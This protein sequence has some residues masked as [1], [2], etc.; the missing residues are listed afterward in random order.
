VQAEFY[1]F[2]INQVLTKCQY[3]YTL[4]DIYHSVKIWRKVYASNILSILQR[5]FG[6]ITEDFSSLDLMDNDQSMDSL[7]DEWLS[8]R[9]DSDVEEFAFW[10]SHMLVS[11]D[12]CSQ[13]TDNEISIEHSLEDLSFDEC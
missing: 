3:L 6:D 2:H 12:E 10:D 7:P 11:F 1:S 5:V 4:N 9:D 8:I 13:V